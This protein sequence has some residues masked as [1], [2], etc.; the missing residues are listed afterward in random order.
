MHILKRILLGISILLSLPLAA[1]EEHFLFEIGALGGCSYYVGEGAEHI[2]MNVRPEYGGFFRYKYNPRWNF[3]AK[4]LYTDLKL[5]YSGKH[6]ENRFINIDATAEFNFL[7]Y[8]IA[9]YDMRIKPYTPFMYLG[10]GATLHNE[11]KDVGV[12]IPFGIGFKWNYAKHGHLS[13]LWQHNLY[14]ADNIEGSPDLSNTYDMNG[15]DIL[16]ND[17]MGNL[18]ISLSFDFGV[19]HSACMVC[20]VGVY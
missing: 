13:I 9:K 20:G 11:F 6:Y 12:Y 4:G 18:V 10:V 1:Q 2:F 17:W 19:R 14:F 3:T 15:W 8:G 5:D 16:N 7:P